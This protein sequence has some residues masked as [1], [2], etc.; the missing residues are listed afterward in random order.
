LPVRWAW[1]NLD[2]QALDTIL[3][4]EI[5]RTTIVRRFACCPIAKAGEPA[6]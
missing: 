2:Y 1:W 5:A 4:D 6:I 3:P